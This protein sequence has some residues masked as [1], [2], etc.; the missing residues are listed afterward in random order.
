MTSG[1][2]TNQFHWKDPDEHPFDYDFPVIYCDAEGC[3]WYG[4]AYASQFAIH[5]HRRHEELVADE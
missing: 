5:W 4:T 1:S 2:A 3:D